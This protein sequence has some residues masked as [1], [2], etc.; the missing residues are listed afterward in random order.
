[1][2]G[3]SILI[4]EDDFIVAKVIEKSLL[5]SGY[6]IAG[7]TGTG[8]EA[9]ALA[10]KE[11]PDLVLMD[12][13]LQGD[14][15][16]ITAAAQIYPV[17]RIPVVFLTA[18]SDQ[19]T[20]S[21]ALDTA[22]YGY[23]IKPFQANTLATTIRVA[24]NKHR[25][26]EEQASR[27]RWL[28]GAL[29]SLSEGVIT[30]DAAGTITL[31]NE[32]AGR[33]TGYLPDEAAG[34]PLHTVLLFKNVQTGKMSPIPI[35]P[36]LSEGMVT[37]VAEGSLLLSRS[38]SSVPVSEAFASPIKNETGAITG[39]A[40]VVYP[41]ERGSAPPRDP[42]ARPERDEAKGPGSARPST[43]DE[44]IDR[45]NALVFLRRFDEALTAY[46]HAVEKGP[47]NYQAWYGRGTALSKTGNL[48]EALRAYDQALSI[49]PRNAQV[50]MAK[51]VLL[52]KAGRD[53]EAQHCFELA[54]L[55]T[56]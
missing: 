48:E 14:M 56:R 21:R 16:G 51:G 35:R 5:E 28:E 45:G 17:L 24:L 20:F 29:Q 8:R 1:V 26:E 34:K 10:K 39:A 37:T 41:G 33:M 9:V 50:L 11:R 54:N 32:H 47:A 27:S 40:I 7:L 18:F 49:H 6:S 52:K 43:A 42:A 3:P 36:V 15:D 55:Y 38:G 31:M 22:P 13:N 30:T 4:V 12:I 23:I 19:A 25:L 46:D 44:W 53:A 2:G